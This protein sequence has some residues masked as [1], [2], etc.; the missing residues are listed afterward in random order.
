MEAP[1]GVQFLAE[2]GD[3]Q[4]TCRNEMRLESKDGQITLDASKIKLP[5]L[6]QGQTSSAGPKQT[7]FEA[8]VCPNGRLFISPAG[9]GSTC[10][11]ST[12]ICQ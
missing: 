3:I 4:A 6:P 5:R 1:K 10:L 8:C 9:T 11:T 12:S 2:A 7:V